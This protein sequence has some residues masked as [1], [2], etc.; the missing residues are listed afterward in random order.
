MSHKS[1]RPILGRV[2]G[3]IRSIAIIAIFDVGVPLAAYSLLRSAGLSTVVTALVLSGVFPALG[4]TIGVIRNRRIDVFGALVLAGIIVGTILGLISHSARLVLAEGSVPTAVFGVACLGSLR[5]RRPLMFSLA[6][7]FAG[8]DT[9]RGREMTRLWQFE[10]YRRV[11]RVI[12]WSG[13]SA[14]CSRPLCG[15]SSPTTPRPGPLWPVPRPRRSSGWPSCRPGRSPTARQQKKSE[16]LAA[17]AAAA[18]AS[19]ARRDH[20]A[21]RPITSG[22]AGRLHHVPRR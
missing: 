1:N 22:R 14:F 21:D 15:S 12:T 3:R 7:E 11:F 9:A 2:G 20:R 8:P 17:A 10:G 18:A 19:E 4:V 6:L 13:A 5:A 16:R